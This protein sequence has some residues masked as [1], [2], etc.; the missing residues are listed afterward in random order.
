MTKGDDR[1]YATEGDVFVSLV[2]GLPHGL[3]RVTGGM[4][5]LILIHAYKLRFTTMKTMNVVTQNDFTASAHSL[6]TD[7]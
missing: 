7:Q 2:S 4:M 5:V 3:F 6:T 1:Y